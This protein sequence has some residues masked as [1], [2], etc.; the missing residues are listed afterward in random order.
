MVK[1]G[2]KG[3]RT[4]E[5]ILMQI[6]PITD[7]AVVGIDP[8]LNGGIGWILP[9]GEA[10]AVPMPTT[11]GQVDYPKI[12]D[13]LSTINPAAIIVEKQ[14][15]FRRRDGGGSEGPVGAFTMGMNY[16]W[17]LAAVHPY[18]HFIVRPQTWKTVL[19][20]GT[21]KA[22]AIAYAQK[23]YPTVSLLATP[24]CSKPSDGIADA[25]CIAAY[26]QKA[27]TRQTSKAS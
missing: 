16:A 9:T 12:T 18:R 25:L 6:K 2:D 11:D 22:K 5:T 10:D 4:R 3:D 20:G 13:L 23:H 19:E 17:I 27:I 7:G 21:S 8:G 1:R 26:G 15:V 24:K 14:Q